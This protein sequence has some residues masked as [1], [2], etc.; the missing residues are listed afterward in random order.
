MAKYPGLQEYTGL[1]GQYRIVYVDEEPVI[2]VYLRSVPALE[3]NSSG[4]LYLPD[5]TERSYPD[6][7]FVIDNNEDYW[8]IIGLEV[9]SFGLT[10]VT[11]FLASLLQEEGDLTQVD[12]LLPIL[13]RLLSQRDAYWGD[14]PT[15]L[16]R[17]YD[18]RR[19]HNV[20]ME[21]HPGI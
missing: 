16:E 11:D 3:Q 13:Q 8:S 7:V 4:Q 21:H 9:Q 17:G 1:N 19:L 15:D 14:L 2:E 10:G 20:W 12:V 6:V 5:P 18:T